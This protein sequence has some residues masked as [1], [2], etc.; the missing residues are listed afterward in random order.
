MLL[1]LYSELIAKPFSFVTLL[2]PV[3]NE[4]VFFSLELKEEEE[5]IF[6]YLTYRWILHDAFSLGFIG[7][8]K[9]NYMYM[10]N[11]CLITQ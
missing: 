2:L 1:L 10:L 4:S 7:C 3:I 8:V 9:D 6:P 11:H 5:K